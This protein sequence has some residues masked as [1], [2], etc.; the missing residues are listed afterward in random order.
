MTSTLEIQ[1]N[2]NIYDKL[3]QIQTIIKDSD[4]KNS[5]NVIASINVLES[6]VESDKC[7]QILPYVL[8][9]F[10]YILQQT[11]SKQTNNTRSI[12]IKFLNTIVTKMSPNST[13]QILKHIF[14]SLEIEQDWQVKTTALN[15]LEKLTDLCTLQISASLANIVP[16]ITPLMNDVK[17]N[18]KD[19]ANTAMIACCD[20]VGNKDIEH[21]TAHIVKA[22]V[23]PSEVP[24]LMHKLAGVVFIQ[25]VK[26]SALAMVSPLL[27]R[28]LNANTT[29]TRRQSGII[30]ENMS[31]LVDDPVDA[32]PFL[33]TLLPALK[34]ATDAMSDPEAR[35]ILERALK[36]IKRLEGICSHL[37]SGILEVN[38]VKNMLKLKCPNLSNTIVEYVSHICCGLALSKDFSSTSWSE[39]STNLSYFIDN[40]NTVEITEELMNECS[41]MVKQDPVVEENDDAELLC[42]C[43]FTLA[44]GTKILLHNTNMKLKRG[45]KYGLISEIQAGKSTFMRSL[46]NGS[47]EG[48]P[49]PSQVKTVFVQSDIIGELSHLTVVEY[50]MQDEEIK[51]IPKETVLKKLEILGFHENSPAKPHVPV[52]TLS[53]G[54]RIKMALAQASMKTPDI[55]LLDDAVKHLDLINIS[56]VKNYIS[57]LKNVTCIMVSKNVGFLN[58]CCTDIIK[59]ENLKIIQTKGN[60]NAYFQKYP[61]DKKLFEIGESEVKFSFPSVSMVEGVK[62]KTKSL[63]KM[64]NVTFTYPINSTPT[65]F[66]V[67]VQVSMGT[68]VAL[69][70]PNGHG[71]STLVKVLTGEVVPQIGVVETNENCRVAY[72]AQHA[73]HH[74][75]NHL[76]MTPREYISW[77]FSGGVDK[78]GIVKMSMVPTEEEK[79]LQSQPFEFSW[80][81]EDTD[82]LKKAMKTISEFS[83][84]RRENRNKEYEYEVR[85]RDGSENWVCSSLLTKRGF[86][87]KTKEIDM[88]IA[89]T[90]GLNMKALTTVN[91]EKH[92][93]EC[94][95]M[96]PEQVSHTRISALSD[97]QKSLV[98]IAAAVWFNPHIIIIDEP[99]NYISGQTLIALANAIKEFE[100]G[101]LV[102]THDL[103]FSKYVSTQT[104]TMYEGKLTITGEGW[105][106]QEDTLKK[107][108]QTS[109]LKFETETEKVDR[110]GNIEKIIQKKQLSKRDLKLR[111]KEIQKKIKNGEELDDEENDIAIENKLI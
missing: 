73:F 46:A 53:G 45:N 31:K 55:L 63:M 101:V 93:K 17:K 27:L 54:W 86:G 32:M 104:W 5:E 70:G 13:T 43:N 29:A 99:T 28:G 3:M 48:F 85:F 110:Y 106:T 91:I 66:D 62:S 68:K 22:I 34:R 67:S 103:E 88:K 50:V 24:E 26:A 7:F 21:M 36:Q 52:H 105:M 108:N 69:Q 64:T 81:D 92:F 47:L 90:N 78:E 75:E 6:L 16:K 61:E 74:I 89:Q 111:I 18:V 9:Y 37:K 51:L 30:I 58:E 39:V 4:K 2:E 94:T 71:K 35:N 40:V 19:A 95:G 41:S 10:G 98:T 33:P 23:S 60:L 20:I 12:A 38:N 72:I 59:M 25:S 102:V 80:K 84:G 14:D 65:I 107:I 76:D 42:D 8:E 44:F 97:G 83:G 15:I 56:F 82:V 49:D 11:T 109:E 77:R 96:E 1:N 57:S 87:K 79:M 100:G